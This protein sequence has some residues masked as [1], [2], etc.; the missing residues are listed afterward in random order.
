MATLDDLAQGVLQQLCGYL[1]PGQAYLAG[2]VGTV[3]QPAFGN[4]GA[5][6]LTISAKAYIGYPETKYLAEDAAQGIAH[7]CVNPAAGWSRP[8]AM[9]C[10][11]SV[12]PVSLFQPSMTVRWN[13]GEVVFAGTASTNQVAGVVVN[14]IAYAY[15]MSGGDT[16]ASVA[17][18]LGAQIP[19]ASVSG[20]TL[21]VTA[22]GGIIAS[23]MV[24]C[25]QA[26]ALT[27]G[28]QDQLIGVCIL[29]PSQPGTDTSG[30]LVRAA[31]ARAVDNLK[32]MLTPAGTVTRLIGLPDGSSAEVLWARDADDDTPRMNNIWR[33]WSYFR[34]QYDTM[35]V[36]TQPS[37]LAANVMLAT[38]ADTLVWCGAAPNL[39]QVMTDGAGDVLVDQAGAVLGSF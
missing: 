31:L 20:A 5:A 30:A 22:S 39:T 29:A 35:Q 28:Q 36:Q 13:P 15:R 1:F 3:T 9:Q 2:A 27:T 18:A 23:A 14:K 19:G 8:S 26:V 33:R 7:V 17:A 24:V 37:V 34:C 12:A 6:S 4:Y 16:P 21:S 10:F 25:D 11:E 32:A 38:G